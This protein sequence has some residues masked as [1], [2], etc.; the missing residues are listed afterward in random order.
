MKPALAIIV[1]VFSAG[2][3]LSAQNLVAQTSAAQTSGGAPQPV[4][5]PS[6]D[7]SLA[8]IQQATHAT[9]TDISKLRIEKW[10]TDAAQKQQ[11]LQMA[12]SLQKNITNAVPGL[13][14]DVQNSKGSVSA[15]FKLYH[16]LN[17]LFEFL[18]SLD[19]AAGSL[20]SQEEYELLTNDAA[21]LDSARRNLS[22]YIQQAVTTLEDKV[23]QAEAPPP[24][25]TPL[26]AK[27]VVV[28]NEDPKKPA[29]PKKKK[30]S[31]LPAQPSR[32]SN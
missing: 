28:D 32:A 11:F 26:P 24:A 8:L 20:G 5:A 22:V 9:D 16:N 25:P 15:T 17:V 4:P 18:S 19:D 23:K 6:L 14:T 3:V 12:A 21:A 13:I 29:T 1:F 7:A 10:K 27:K 30:T 31:S 2:L